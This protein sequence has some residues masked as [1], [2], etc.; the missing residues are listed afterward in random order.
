MTSKKIQG[1]LGFMMADIKDVPLLESYLCR[2]C[3]RMKA[4][5]Q[6]SNR[7][8]ATYKYKKSNK[9]PVNKITAKLRCRLCAGEQRHELQCQGPCGTYR[10]LDRF[11]KNARKNPEPWCLECVDWKEAAEPGIV[12]APAPN[13]AL[14]PDEEANL[15][16]EERALEF[17]PEGDPDTDDEF[18]EDFYTTS[19]VLSVGGLLETY[20]QSE[21]TTRFST[22]QE[23]LSSHPY[24]VGMTAPGPGLSLGNPYLNRCEE[25][26]MKSVISA[27]ASM[28]TGGSVTQSSDTN[29]GA[30]ATDSQIKGSGRAIDSYDA[31]GNLHQRRMS[32]STSGIASNYSQ[33]VST[34]PS[35]SR[36]H[37]NWARAACGRRNPPIPFPSIRRP[38]PK[39]SRGYDSDDSPDEM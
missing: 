14:A 22:A 27:V 1:N 39:Q 4:P 33:F 38:A 34:S 18:D 30:V 36:G 29:K 17:T 35:I 25:D 11:S 19:S 28:S 13:G 7:E 26:C 24:Q 32:S 16:L 10:D 3:G 6:F 23:N 31:S 15:I 9:L 20:D 37:G 2:E 8:L 5:S 21:T 12:P